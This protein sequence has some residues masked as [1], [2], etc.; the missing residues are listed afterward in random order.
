MRIRCARDGAPAWQGW[1]GVVGL[2]E[3]GHG[4]ARQAWQGQAR[5]GPARLGVAWQAWQCWAGLGQA[6][7]GRAGKARPGVAGRGAAGRG[8]AGE[9]C[10]GVARIVLVWQARHGAARPGKARQGTWAGTSA[11]TTN[12]HNTMEQTHSKALMAY[13]GQ[14]YDAYMTGCG[15]IDWLDKPLPSWADYVCNP[16]NKR[17]VEAWVDVARVAIRIETEVRDGQL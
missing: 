11:R 14:L 15:G 4:L 9:A 12:Q 6:W 7:F 13:A 5:Q 16:N 8:L 1:R 10:L 3:A 17:R 2:G